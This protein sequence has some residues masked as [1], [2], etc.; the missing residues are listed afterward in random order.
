MALVIAIFMLL[1]FFV[2]DAYTALYGMALALACKCHIRSAY[3][4]SYLHYSDAS[5]NVV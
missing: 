5:T 4:F 2:F 1:F 3:S